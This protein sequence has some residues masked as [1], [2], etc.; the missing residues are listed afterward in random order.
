M[1]K[2]QTT[3]ELYLKIM[4]FQHSSRTINWEFGYWGGTVDRWYQEGLPKKRGFPKD[5]YYGQS[6]HGP[7]AASGFKK[8]R[9]LDYDIR[10]YFNFDENI[11]LFPFEYWIFPQFEKQIVNE[12]DKY[13]EYYDIDGI[14]KRNFKDGSSMP[15]FLEYP[16][17][18]RNTWEKMKEERFNLKNIGKRY[19]QNAHEFINKSIDRTFPLALMDSY[20]TAGF[21][22]TLRFLIGE[23]DLYLLYYDDPMFLKDIL[24]HLCELW[25]LIAEEL[26][27]KIEFDVACFWED[28]AGKQGS[29][30]SPLMFKEFM[31]PSYKRLIDFLKSKKI[32]IFTVDTDGYVEELIPLFLEV[33]VNAMYPF[34][35]QAG[36]DLIKIRKKYP[37]LR[38]LGGFDKNTLS[39]GKENIDKEFE[40]IPYLIKSGGYIPFA[41]HLIPPNTSWENF[42]YY[43]NKLEE[44]I[45]STSVL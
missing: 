15:C 11:T 14:K 9:I 7:G 36:N 34:E 22:G 42:K 5:V 38:I 40:K 21:F 18:N 1:R 2:Q 3:R 17:K 37:N 27:S 25:I 29:M 12:D 13:V 41:D 8:G 23:K 20:P 32:D 10:D 31:T 43:R 35:Q 28:M 4:N 26:T 39:K 45:Y 6:I 19:Y 16:V 44:I 30:I 33:G 24:K